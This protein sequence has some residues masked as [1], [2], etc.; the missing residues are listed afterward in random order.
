MKLLLQFTTLI[1]LYGLGGCDYLGTF[2]KNIRE[3]PEPWQVLEP[4]KSPEIRSRVEIVADGEGGV[5]EP[6]DLVQIATKFWSIEQSKFFPSGDWWLWTGFRS[7][8]ETSFFSSNPAQRSALLGLKEGT[9]MKFL[10]HRDNPM[11]ADKLY[12]NPLGDPKYYSWRKNNHDFGGIFTPYKSGY[13]LV[14]IKRV[15]KGQAKYRTVRLLD[16]SPV[17][18]CQGLNCYVTEEKRE[19]WFDEAK[20]EARCP[21]EKI[22]TFEYGPVESSNGKRGS[23]PVQGY[24]DEWYKKAWDKLPAGVQLK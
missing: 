17:Q 11:D 10:E 16:D 8:V 18:I 23:S 6:G 24:F 5:I 9:V 21:D 3:F 14:E 13:S 20:I 4:G 2:P 12:V 1:A 7:S 19:V 15:C 22:A